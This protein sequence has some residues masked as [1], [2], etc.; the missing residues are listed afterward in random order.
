MKKI[1]TST[2]IALIEKKLKSK[3][4]D[5]IMCT[6][7]A[8]WL[9]EF[10]TKKQEI[11][12]ISENDI[13]WDDAAQKK[14]DDALDALINKDM[15]LAYLLGST[16]FCGLDILVKPPI[17]IP[18]PETEELTANLIDRLKPLRNEP[19]WILDLCTGSGCIAL[20]LADA[21]PK[22]KVYGT[23]I[24]NQALALAKENARH[25]HIA[26]VEFLNSDLF[27][28][29]PA[30]FTFDLIVSNPPYIPEK[31]WATL[32]KSVLQWEDKNAL[33]AADDGLAL[34]K[35]IIDQAPK[36]LKQ[37]ELLKKN[38][39][40]QLILEMDYTQGHAIADF[41]EQHNYNQIHIQKDLEGKD[42]VAIGRI[43]NVAITKSS[44]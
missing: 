42:R 6:Q 18:R 14:L 11:N 29:I 34:I 23:D 13:N 9:V 36:Y 10:I 43:D 33:I 4:D 2:L 38:K 32:D 22:A 41:M 26:N 5:E 28:Q 19:L 1:Q 12:L 16:P 40:P 3:F 35:R 15:P 20:A 31:D 44:R 39:I 37:N 27:A 25:N 30:A 8:W 21:L 17:L 7:Y 24:S